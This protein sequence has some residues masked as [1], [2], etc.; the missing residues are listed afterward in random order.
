MMSP[1]FS[2]RC[3]PQ[4]VENAALLL[5]LAGTL[6]VGVARAAGAL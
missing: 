2:T 6:V 4:F 1:F 3:R 5:G